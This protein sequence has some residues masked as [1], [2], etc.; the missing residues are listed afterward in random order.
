MVGLV[1]ITYGQTYNNFESD[2][3]ADS[4]PYKPSK[5]QFMIRGY[6]HTGLN[7]MDTN[8][9]KES[10]YVGSA[11]APIFLFKHSDRLMFESELEFVLEGN[12]KG[13]V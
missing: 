9:E 5:T 11:F 12:V 6:G 13:M 7:F 4:Q 3:I 10:S 2:S 8:G 1:H